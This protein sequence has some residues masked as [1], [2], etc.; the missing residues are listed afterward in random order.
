MKTDIYFNVSSL[1]FW[2]M[3]WN[4]FVYN[5]YLFITVIYSWVDLPS[6]SAFCFAFKKEEKY[7]KSKEKKYIY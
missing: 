2:N 1:F 3:F 4:V 6:F 7:K 5:C